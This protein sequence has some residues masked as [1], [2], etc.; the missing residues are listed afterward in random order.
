MRVLLTNDDGIDAPG[1]QALLAELVRVAEVVVIAPAANQSAVARSITLRRALTVTER[2]LAGALRSFAVDGTPVDCVRFAA[3][4]IGGAPFDAVVS[5]AN[6]GLNLGDDVT[7]SGT[8]AAAMEGVLLGLPAI[9]VSQGGLAGGLGFVTDDAYDFTAGARFTAGLLERVVHHGLAPGLLLNVN[10]PARPAGVRLTSLGRR[11]YRDEL[12]L[13]EDRGHQKVYRI[14]G[15]NVGYE[16]A[17][18]SDFAA[19]AAGAI[20]VTPVHFD[21]APRATIEWL[22]ESGLDA[23]L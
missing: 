14:Y 23:L 1:I 8:V 16:E 17:P 15:A 20:A 4:G 7:Y 3:L 12:S 6:H 11:V 9:A 2:D 21:L 5:G 13:V 19:V 22:D 10:V 18:G